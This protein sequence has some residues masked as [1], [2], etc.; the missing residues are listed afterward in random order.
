MMV[1][2]KYN[3]VDKSD[4]SNCGINLIDLRYWNLLLITLLSIQLNTS[5]NH[6]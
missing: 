2:I 3:L 5:L 6:Q 1:D 4:K